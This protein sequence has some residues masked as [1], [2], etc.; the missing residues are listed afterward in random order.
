[1]R[2]VLLIIMCILGFTSDS[3][4]ADYGRCTERIMSMIDS[5]MI[6]EPVR[7]ERG[8][9]GDL[10]WQVEGPGSSWIVISD[11]EFKKALDKNY[12]ASGSWIALVLT[13]HEHTGKPHILLDI[14][15]DEADG[16]WFNSI[17]R[18]EITIHN[19][20]EPLSWYLHEWLRKQ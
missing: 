3:E 1:M 20:P 6:G 16:C 11:E 9:S 10:F 14:I 7:I 17:Y 2:N 5:T 12:H 15:T 19:V 8:H 13:F 18:R 4:A